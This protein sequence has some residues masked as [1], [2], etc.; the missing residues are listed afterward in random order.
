VVYEDGSIYEGERV[1]GRPNG[2]GSLTWPN[3]QGNYDGDFEGGRRHGYG[4]CSVFLGENRSVA[5]AI[6]GK[7]GVS[8]VS[9]KTASG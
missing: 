1:K 8:Q 5:G 6:A 4:I 7:P 9:P 3:K 2:R